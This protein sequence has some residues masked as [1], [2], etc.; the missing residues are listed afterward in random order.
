[1]KANF[2]FLLIL[3]AIWGSVS[4][5]ASVQSLDKTANNNGGVIEY[6]TAFLNIS[7]FDMDRGI[8]HTEKTET[9]RFSTNFPKEFHGVVVPLVSNITTS[10]DN[11]TIFGSD[12]NFE[13]TGKTTFF[14][15]N[16]Q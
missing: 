5:A 14:I 13:L 9:G 2:I 6:F 3:G 7:Y 16:V 4:W 8:F 12:I 10:A 1:M 11:K 15:D